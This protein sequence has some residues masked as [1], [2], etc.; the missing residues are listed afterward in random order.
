MSDVVFPDRELKQR[1]ATL[2]QIMRDRDLDALIV[3]VPENI[4]YLTGLDHWGFF[5]C[6]VLIVPLEGALA[7]TCR[8]MERITVENQS[9]VAY[10]G[11]AISIRVGSGPGEAPLASADAAALRVIDA[12]VPLTEMFG[13]SSQ[14]RSQTAGRGTFTMEPHVYEKVPEQIANQIII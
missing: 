12:H 7:L 9:D 1:L 10:R 4:Y 8:A 11:Q 2:R 13:Y 6:H 3:S 5:A 14:I